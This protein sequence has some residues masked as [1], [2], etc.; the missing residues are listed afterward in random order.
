MK[1]R[2]TEVHEFWFGDYR[3]EEEVLKDK[4]PLWF[5]KQRDIDDAIR[6]RFGDLVEKAAAGQIDVNLFGPRETLCVILLLDQFTRN[7]YRGDPRSFASDARARELAEQLLSADEKKLRPLEKVFLY[8][9]FE[10]SEDLDDQKKSVALFR[11]LL[12]SVAEDLRPTF[13]SFYDY[14]VRHHDIVARFGRFP[15]RNLILDRASTVD[16]ERFLE[17]PG[18]SF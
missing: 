4:G 8:L 13:L 5:A 6:E 9:P 18:S 12:D 14:A 15:H 2:L 11:G 16:E 1:D 7:I 17:E 10:H 3:S